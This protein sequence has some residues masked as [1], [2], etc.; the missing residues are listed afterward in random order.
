MAA[1]FQ[2]QTL[3]VSI[4]RDPQEI[5]QFVVNPEN[6]PTWASAF[7]QAIRR[8][9]SGWIIETT[10]GDLTLRFVGENT[11]GV[12]DHYLLGEPGVEIYVPMRIVPNGSGSEVLITLFRQPGISGPEFGQDVGSVTRDLRRLKDVLET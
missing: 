9:D 12:A 4:R 5:Y 8:T 11:L 2:S 7:C 1:T 10:G 6:L 3:S